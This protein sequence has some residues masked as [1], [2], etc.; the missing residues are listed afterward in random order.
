MIELH[1]LEAE[2]GVLGAMMLQPHLIDVISDGLSADAFA[3]TENA[4][5]F[6][7]IRGLNDAGQPID[8]ITLAE[9]R[10]Y[11]A[12][13]IR[14][15][16][17]AAEVIK[18]TPSVANAKAYAK[19]VRDR[20]V[21]RQISA[22]AAQVDEIAH[23][24]SSIEDKIAQAQAAILSLDTSGGDAECQLVGDLWAEHIEVLQARLDRLKDGV[25]IDGLTTGLPDLDKFVQGMKPGQMIVVAGRPAMGK[26]TL[27]MN[28][29]AD[30]GINQGKPVA[31][32]SLE[33]SKTQLIDRLIAAVGG[34]PLPS[35]K[36][37][38][39]ASDYETELAAAGLK[40]QRSKIVVSDVPVMSMA[41]IR[42]IVRRQKHRLG[43]MALVVIDYLGLVE[44]EGGS[45]VDDVTTM[46]RQIKLLAR[47]IGCPVIILSQ[48]N[49][50]CESRPDKRPVLSDLRESGAIEQDADIVMFVYRDEVYYPNSEHKGI[51]EILVRKNRDGEIGSVFTAFQGDRSRFVPLAHSAFSKPKDQEEGW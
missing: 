22:A 31:V 44:G 18:N 16:A 47:E 12:G 48:L 21:S 25:T 1:S 10:E 34:I 9:R 20:A 40:V 36:T 37:G 13:D 8:V 17:Y 3:W 29:A 2:H 15:M 27:A 39:C 19:I 26:T 6:R 14:T 32:I 11:L 4:E 7:L 42:S 38:E 23:D 50:G 24:E 35:M 49:R 41:R 51:G 43:G 45:R 5:L 46:S 33:M 30:V 28:I